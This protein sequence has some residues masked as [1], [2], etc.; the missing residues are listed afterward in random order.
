M[1]C[2]A[3]TAFALVNNFKAN[4]RDQLII[5]NNLNVWGIITMREPSGSLYL[6]PAFNTTSAFYFYLIQLLPSTSTYPQYT[7]HLLPIHIIAL[8]FRRFI[9]LRRHSKTNCRFNRSPLKTLIAHL[10]T[11]MSSFTPHKATACQKGLI[12]PERLQGY[13]I[14]PPYQW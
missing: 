11:R 7:P 10:L 6:P 8:V 3:T 1:C 9:P 14:L 5:L 2:S 4:I 13:V 12:T